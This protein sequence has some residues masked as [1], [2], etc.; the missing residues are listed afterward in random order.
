[1]TLTASMQGSW[2]QLEHLAARQ[3]SHVCAEA[4]LISARADSLQLAPASS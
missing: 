3:I 4:K 2:S 1:M